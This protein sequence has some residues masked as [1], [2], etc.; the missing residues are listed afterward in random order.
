MPKT[1]RAFKR[2]SLASILAQGETRAMISHAW[3]SGELQIQRALNYPPF[4]YGE[5]PFRR[6]IELEISAARRQDR[7]FSGWALAWNDC[8]NHIYRQLVRGRREHLREEQ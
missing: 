3:K 7:R 8:S 6:G 1:S 4:H 5:P 2:I